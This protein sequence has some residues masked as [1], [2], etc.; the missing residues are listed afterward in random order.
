VQSRRSV[1]HAAL[2][3]A[4]ARLLGG[5]LAQVLMPALVA[6]AH[7]AAHGSFAFFAH[8]DFGVRGG[9]VQRDVDGGFA[10]RPHAHVVHYEHLEARDDHRH[11]VEARHDA[12]ELELPFV[13]GLPRPRRH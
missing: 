3:K 13:V 1:E 10:V 2:A 5:E 8:F 7:F 4:H 12:V 6:P 11:F 9:N